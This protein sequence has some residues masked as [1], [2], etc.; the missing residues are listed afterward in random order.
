MTQQ[1]QGKVKKLSARAAG[2]RD[3]AISAFREA[4]LLFNNG[5]LLA[6]HGSIFFRS[7][8]QRYS[9]QAQISKM[10][11][12]LV[13]ALSLTRQASRLDGRIKLIESSS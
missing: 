9:V 11:R 7:R 8:K 12:S 4:E 2:K 5:M 1:D 10:E 3:Q 6:I 13:K